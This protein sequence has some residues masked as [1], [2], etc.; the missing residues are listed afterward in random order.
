MNGGAAGNVGGRRQRRVLRAGLAAGTLFLVAAL[1]PAAPPQEPVPSDP[2]FAAASWD[3]ATALTRTAPAQYGGSLQQVAAAIGA[4]SY[5]S[6][7]YTG[8]GIDVAVVDTGVA[9]VAGLSTKGKIVNGPDLSFDSQSEKLRHLDAN[10]HGTHL[11][12]IIAGN[13]PGQLRVSET[14]LSLTDQTDIVE[15]RGI[16][17]GSRVVNVK[18]GNHHGAVDVSQVIAAI[19]WV[20]EHRRD[21][22]LDIRVLNLAYGTDGTQASTSDPLAYAVERAWKAGI[23]VVVAT[24]NDGNGAPVRNPALDPYVIA[25]GASDTTTSTTFVSGFSNCGTKERSTDVVAPGRSIISLR[26]P[27][28]VVDEANPQAVVAE[29]FFLGS[30]T[31][32]ASAVVSG[33]VALMLDQRPDLTPDQ[34]KATLMKTADPVKDTSL[35]Q[36]A[37]QIDLAEARKMSPPRV[38]QT[39]KRASGLGSLEKARGSFHLTL[40]GVALEGEQDIF[41]QPWNAPYWAKLAA[42]NMTWSDGDWNGSTWTG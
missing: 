13:D 9:P 15:F 2:P 1:I 27:G 34:V 32:Q 10:G 28:S 19:D 42:N 5:W 31:S 26:T 35:C 14:S 22:G 8:Q 40:E 33:A 20:I 36:G 29:R 23:V 3:T 38:E 6:A 11:A 17:P 30:G 7:G 21:N 37:G 12:G 25:V 39:W 41:G 24:G 4:D 16:A 18:A